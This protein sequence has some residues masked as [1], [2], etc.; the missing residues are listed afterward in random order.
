[1][2]K[3]ML[4]DVSKCTA[5]RACQ[6][7]CKAWN[8]LPGETTVCLGCYD[9]P[10]DLSPDTW[11]RIAFW[12]LEREGG[13]VAWVFRPVRCMHCKDAP[14]VQVCPTGALYHHPDG[15]TALDPSKCNGCGYCTQFCPFD[16]PRLKDKDL[17]GKGVAT[18]CTFCEDRTTNGEV[19]ACAHACPTGAI[20]FGDRAELLSEGKARVETLKGRGFSQANL[21][22]EKELGGLGMIHVLTDP[23]ET[24]GLP[25]KPSGAAAEAWQPWIQTLG[26]V[27]VGATLVGVAVNWLV[28]RKNIKAEEEA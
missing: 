2:T 17:W 15:F 4:V 23:P 3:A 20:T 14:C 26:G 12:E 24:F 19:P 8:D 18:K 27:A 25:A 5:C 28:A 9:N 22:G 7:A 13:Q 21:Y 16:V 1:M 6:V 10:P 11:N